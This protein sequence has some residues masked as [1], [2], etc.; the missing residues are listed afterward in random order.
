MREYTVKTKNGEV[1]VYRIDNDVNGN[2]RYI[3]HYLTL[4]LD[5]YEATDKTR[6]LGLSKY[7]GK[8]FGGGFVFQSYNIEQDVKDFIEQ[9]G[10]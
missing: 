2:P 9:L 1:D 4:G 7:R 5:N 3:I 8:Q 6:A 10:K